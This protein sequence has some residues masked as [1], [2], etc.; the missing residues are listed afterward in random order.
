MVAPMDTE[1]SGRIRICTSFDVLDMGP[2]YPDR[3]IVL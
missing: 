3:N 2:V 1:L